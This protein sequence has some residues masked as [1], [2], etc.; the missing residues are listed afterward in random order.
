MIQRIAEQVIP[1]IAASNSSSGT[2]PI[3]NPEDTTN[4]SQPA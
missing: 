3:V 4:N 1:L 2:P